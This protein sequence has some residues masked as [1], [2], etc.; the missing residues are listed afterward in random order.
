MKRIALILLLAP[1]LLA[2]QCEDDENSGFETTYII[3]NDTGTDLYLLRA[4]N[5]FL[6]IKDQ[7]SESIG[8]ELNSITEP[9]PP[10]EAQVIGGIQLFERVNADFILKYRQDPLENEV[11]TLTEPSVNRFE[12]KLFI[13]E[14][15]LD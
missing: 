6:Q 14:S 5:R 3:E 4:D 7:S 12:Y 8:S 15:D 1:F 13:A 11:W 9:V 10:E 2:T